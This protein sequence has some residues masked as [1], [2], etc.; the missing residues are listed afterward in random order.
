M[1]CILSTKKVIINEKNE[2]MVV[3]N[4]EKG[5]TI[6]SLYLDE[7]IYLEPTAIETNRFMNICSMIEMLNV[8]DIVSLMDYEYQINWLFDKAK[9]R[10][11][12]Y[13]QEEIEEA[14]DQAYLILPKDPHF[15]IMKEHSWKLEKEK[16]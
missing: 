10:G 13:T 7:H 9:E 3:V 11:V 5:C 6:V 2:K 4:K 16:V 15:N 14:D 8:V 1:E 12:L